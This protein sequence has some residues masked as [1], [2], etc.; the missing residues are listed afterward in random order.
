MNE[1]YSRWA[2][3]ED[4]NMK[5]KSNNKYYEEKLK[6]KAERKVIKNGYC[7]NVISVIVNDGE[8]MTELEIALFADDGNLCFGYREFR[9]IRDNEYEVTIHTD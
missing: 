6:N 1:V 5:M 7:H 2:F 9:K 4:E 8:E 3:T